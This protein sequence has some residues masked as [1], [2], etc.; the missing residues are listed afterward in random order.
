MVVV[1]YI[2]WTVIHN[3]IKIMPQ[4]YR[5]AYHE[6]VVTLIGNRTRHCWEECIDRMQPVLAMPLGLLFV[7]VAFDEGS[8][9]KV[10]EMKNGIQRKK[11]RLGVV[12]SF[13]A[14]SYSCF[15]GNTHGFEYPM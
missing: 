15:A 3:F 6:Y 4:K 14:F 12:L 5:D 11:F 2:M 8:K 1:N 10:G 9:E 7:D 13:I